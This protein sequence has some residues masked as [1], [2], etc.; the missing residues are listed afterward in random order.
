[1]VQSSSVVSLPVLHLEPVCE[2]LCHHK[3]SYSELKES[4]CSS[5]HSLSLGK[6]MQSW[7]QDKTLSNC[8]HFLSLAHETWKQLWESYTVSLWIC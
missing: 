6:L 5:N 2:I 1:M 8:V 3:E 7:G 4:Y